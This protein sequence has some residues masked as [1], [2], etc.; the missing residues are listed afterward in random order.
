MSEQ[1]ATAT[2]EGTQQHTPPALG[3]ICWS[4]LMTKDLETAKKF[5]SELFGWKL[6]ESNIGDMIYTEIAAGDEHIGGMMQMTAECGGD[7][8]SHWMSYVAV[9]D[10]EASAKRVEELGG[11]VSVPPMDIPNVGRFCIIED[12]TGATISLYESRHN[13][14]S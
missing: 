12:P 4:E 1:T 14:A 8:P 2:E 9:E 10:V 7:A 3:T 6:T 5:Y 13:P 11:K